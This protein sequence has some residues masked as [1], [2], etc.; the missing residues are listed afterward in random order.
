MTTNMNELIAVAS[1]ISAYTAFM[2]NTPLPG[3][4]VV[5]LRK[6][7]ASLETEMQ[8]PVTPPWLRTWTFTGPG[9]SGTGYDPWANRT[10]WNSGQ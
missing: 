3:A 8:G 1:E 4:L 10:I 7:L 9:I 6:A 2:P 5:K